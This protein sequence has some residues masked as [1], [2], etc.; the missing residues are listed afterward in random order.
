MNFN[1]DKSKRLYWM[2][3]IEKV[4]LV[5]TAALLGVLGVGVGLYAAWFPG[6][7]LVPS[8]SVPSQWFG[9]GF[10]GLVGLLSFRR[11]LRWK[12]GAKR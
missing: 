8:V 1:C 11:Y 5:T 12:Y 3:E 4:K 10:G 2:N 9:L 7:D 6:T